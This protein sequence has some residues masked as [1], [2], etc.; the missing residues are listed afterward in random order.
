MSKTVSL[1]LPDCFYILR[2]FFCPPTPT[3]SQ[4][5]APY[6]SHLS[7]PNYCS[8]FECIFSYCM[9]PDCMFLDCMFPDCLFSDCLFPDNL[10][11]DCLFPVCIFFEGLFLNC[12]F[13]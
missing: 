11:P 5:T 6:I 13:P 10:F 8:F 1:L 12:L 4:S 9:F 3:V 2:F 7:C